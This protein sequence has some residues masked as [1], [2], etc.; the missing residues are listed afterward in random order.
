MCFLL[1]YP[2]AF[3]VTGKCFFE[4]AFMGKKN[5]IVICLSA[6]GQWGLPASAGEWQRRG[7]SSD[8][9]IRKPPLDEMGCDP[10]IGMEAG[11]KSGF[12]SSQSLK[13]LS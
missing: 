12:F 4:L 8:F 1:I 11:E 6:G 5:R 13:W 10:G 7:V 3:V 9:S 2:L